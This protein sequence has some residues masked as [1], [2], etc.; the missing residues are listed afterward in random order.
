MASEKRPRRTSAVIVDGRAPVTAHTARKPVSLI[1]TRRSNTDI[2]GGHR[3]VLSP[4]TAQI[5]N[6]TY[7][8]A[9]NTHSAVMTGRSAGPPRRASPKLKKTMLPVMNAENGFH[10]PK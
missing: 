9:A 7:D 8:P 2:R 4:R 5:R 1:A 10:K 3:P 6:P